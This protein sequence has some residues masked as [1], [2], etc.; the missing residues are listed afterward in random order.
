LLGLLCA[1]PVG[2]YLGQSPRVDR[3]VSP[4]IFLTY[5][6]PKVVLVPVLILWLGIGDGSKIA[7]IAVLIFFQ[8]LVAARDASLQVPASY[9]E[10]IRSMRAGRWFTYRHVI[11]PACLPKVF[12]TLRLNLG[13][14]IAIL[15]F[16]ETYATEFGIGFYIWD[17]FARFDY[18]RIYF[19][20]MLLCFT[21]WLLFQ[22]LAWIERYLTP[23]A[24]RK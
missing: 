14:S 12:T 23:W 4:V 7:L 9:L 22:L 20:T 11:V 19:A 16:I 21:G 5:T 1:L 13:T 8:M 10:A 17:H 3:W 24:F 15:F 2:L 18:A 6:F